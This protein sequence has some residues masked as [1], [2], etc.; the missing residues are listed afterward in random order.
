MK[1]DTYVKMTGYFKS[2]PSQRKCL[3]VMNKLC[4]LIIVV[5]YPLLLLY[6]LSLRT[7][8]LAT[9]IIV[10]MNAFII[11]TVFRFLI[12]RQ[13]PYEKFETAP[14]IP[15]VKKGNS[16]PSRHVFSSFM[17]AFTMCIY[18]PWIEVGI[19]LLIVAILIAIIRVVAGIHFISDVLAG[20]LFAA[21]ASLFYFI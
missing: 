14:A 11:L 6:L 19:L 8:E 20:F 16:F 7:P 2:H 9:A 1:K 3:K 12:N 4:T 15:K 13:R 18:G 21:A 10:P 5:A 17:I